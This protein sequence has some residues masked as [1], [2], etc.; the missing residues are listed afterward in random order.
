MSVLNFCI[1][2][3]LQIES[4]GAERARALR[5]EGGLRRLQQLPRRVQIRRPS[6]LGTR[7]LVPVG[8]VLVDM[9]VEVA[10][11]LL[12]VVVVDGNEMLKTRSKRSRLI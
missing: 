8:P 5:G 10:Q 12:H 11:Q 2:L 1:D 7:L 4:V 6:L 3:R 9:V